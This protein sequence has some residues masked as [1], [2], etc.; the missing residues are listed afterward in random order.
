MTLR[1][2]EPL[3]PN[4]ALS[5]RA[6]AQSLQLRTRYAMEALLGDSAGG[7]P[8]PAADWEEAPDNI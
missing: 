1:I 6:A 4:P 7:Y 2:G 3:Y 5:P 8:L